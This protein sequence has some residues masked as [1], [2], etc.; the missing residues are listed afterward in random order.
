MQKKK[1]IALIW[2]R[3]DLRV[4][5]H[6]GFYKASQECDQ[7]FAYYTFDERHFKETRWGFKKSEKFRT[8][9]LLETITELKKELSK[10]NITLIIDKNYADE[11][12]PK[13]IEKLLVTDLYFQN[14]WT[15]EERI[16]Y[17]KTKKKSFRKNKTSHIL[18]SIFV[19]S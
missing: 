6:L 10:K 7:I 5:D 3:N 17:R 2:L 1:R 19:S 18:R 11:G 15:H 12:I 8:K 14:E 16:V 4:S 9:F 13:W